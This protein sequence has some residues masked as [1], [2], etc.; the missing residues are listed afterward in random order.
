MNRGVDH[1]PIFF[2]DADRVDFGRLL[3]VAATATDT[4]LAAYCLMGNHFHLLLRTEHERLPEFMHA[5][6]TPF[7][8]HLN[9]RLG[10]DGPLFKGRFH[11]V[12]VECDGH[13]MMAVRYIHRNPL[14]LPGVERSD[15]YRWSS[16]RAYLGA[17]RCPDW[18]SL[19]P[20]ADYF[21]G[22]IE[23]YRVFVDD[24]NVLAA[25][26]DTS[27][28]D[29]TSLISLIAAEHCS[30][31]RT[32]RRIATTVAT[33]LC[34]DPSTVTQFAADHTA[35]RRTPG[36]VR[37]ARFR[38]RKHLADETAVAEVLSAVSTLLA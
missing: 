8:R 19:D 10:R 13:L 3:G 29:L 4:E 37:T 9:D 15:Q 14:A 12:P 18:L 20:L 27:E 33:L 16:H 23:R 17:Q 31:D 38:A 28:L 35:D 1:Q 5:L 21:D 6:C 30:D 34:H 7:V 25:G 2:N 36:A 26:L 11:S 24:S 22:D 32:E